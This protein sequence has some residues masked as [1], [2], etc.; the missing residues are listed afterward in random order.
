MNTIAGESTTS[1][2]NFLKAIDTVPTPEISY[3]DDT[4][5]KRFVPTGIK[6][7]ISLPLVR[8]TK[9]PLFGIN[10]DG[11]IPQYN[12]KNAWSLIHANLFPVQIVDGNSTVEITQDQFTLPIQSYYASHRYIEGN[13]GV[14]LRI[15]SNT[16][17][18]GNMMITQASGLV[19]DYY[20]SS[21][22][23]LGLRFSNSTVYPLDY[24]TGNFMLAD[25]SLNRNVSIRTVRKDPNKTLD[26]AKKIDEISKLVI[27]DTATIARSEIVATQF[28]EDWLLFAPL[29]DLPDNTSNQLTIEVFFDYS[30]VQFFVPIFPVIALGANTVQRQVLRWTRSFK[31]RQI[32]TILKDNCTY[33]PTPLLRDDQNRKLEVAPI[34]GE[35]KAKI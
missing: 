34:K 25:L 24:A 6:V 31:N 7:K 11:F 33:L 15:T 8:N 10:I 14:G 28:Q 27:N 20:S 18:P 13:V 19:R 9:D 32:S 21:E 30:Q 4:S 23:Y 17:Q 35:E 2:T 3:F 16:T 29:S 1:P 26:L 22:P 5:F 12:I